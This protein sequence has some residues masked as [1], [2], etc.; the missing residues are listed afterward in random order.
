[1][2]SLIPI[3]FAISRSISVPETPIQGCLYSPSLIKVGTIFTTVCDG[4]A[5]P[6]PVNSPVDDCIAVY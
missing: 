5:N 1:M 6:T 3:T 2:Y 4:I